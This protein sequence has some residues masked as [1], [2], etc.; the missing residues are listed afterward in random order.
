MNGVRKLESLGY[1]PVLIAWWWAL[2]FRRNTSVWQTDGRTPHNSIYC[3]MH[4]RR[5]VKS[6]PWTENVLVSKT[7]LRQC[8]S[9]AT[10]E[11]SSI[12]IDCSL[13]RHTGMQARTGLREGNKGN[14]IGTRKTSVISQSF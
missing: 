6:R 4:M 5:A 14:I 3:A 1:N 10:S 7:H 9:H 8:S 12:L 13:S 11:T 2:L